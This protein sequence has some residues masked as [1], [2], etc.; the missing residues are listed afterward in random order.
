[1]SEPQ[2]QVRYCLVRDGDP[3]PAETYLRDDDGFGAIQAVNRAQSL[4]RQ[5]GPCTVY[6]GERFLVRYADGRRQ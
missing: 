3:H 5:G 6:V 4:S 1:M 2:E